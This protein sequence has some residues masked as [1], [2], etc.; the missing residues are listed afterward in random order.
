MFRIEDL[1]NI[2]EERR[3][4]LIAYFDAHSQ[5][6]VISETHF[7]IS[8][9]MQHDNA[10]VRKVL[11]GFIIPYIKKAAPTVISVRGRSDGCKAQFECA[12]HFDWV[13]A[14]SKQA[15]GLR[16]HWSFFASCYGKSCVCIETHQEEQEFPWVLGTVVKPSHY[17]PQSVDH[18]A[19]T[20]RLDSIKA[21]DPVLEVALWEALEPESASY[22]ESEITMLVPARRVRVVGVDL[23][24]VESVV[25]YRKYY[26]V[27]LWLI[28]W[29]GYGEDHHTW[30]PWE[31]FLTPETQA[32]A[33]KVKEQ[34]LRSIS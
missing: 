32:E 16:V 25:Q 19:S 31:H 33:Q 5:P 24:Q 12:S 4:E 3:A 34:T 28:K 2:S 23:E 15:S 18:S 22:K 29:R 14:Q 21:G 26:R 17:A 20:P 9:D 10:F 11:D 30:E 27:E 1:V 13:L 7:I 6:R 8:A